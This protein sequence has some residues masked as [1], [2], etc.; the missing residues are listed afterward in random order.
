M[1]FT[2]KKF[3]FDTI[4]YAVIQFLLCCLIFL[5]VAFTSQRINFLL[6]LSD[7]HPERSLFSIFGIIFGFPGIFGCLVANEIYLISSGI[8]VSGSLLAIPLRMTAI[9]KRFMAL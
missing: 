6:S 3:N 5:M 8:S 2:Q 7:L 1:D 9:Q 4:K